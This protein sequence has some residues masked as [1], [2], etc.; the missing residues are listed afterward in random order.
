MVQSFEHSVQVEITEPF[1]EQNTLLRRFRMDFIR[2]PCDF[3]LEL[4]FQLIDNTFADIT[5]RSDVI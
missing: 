2:G 4:F 1:G 3:E 5:E